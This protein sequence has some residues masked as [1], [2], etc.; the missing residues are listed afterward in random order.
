[1]HLRYQA[2]QIN[3]YLTRPRRALEVQDEFVQ[4]KA[5]QILTVFLRS[6]YPTLQLIFAFSYSI[7][8]VATLLPPHRIQAFLSVLSAS[9]QG[10]ST[11]KRDVAVQC[12]ESLLSRPDYRQEVWK[13]P[14]ILSG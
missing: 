12:L 6:F 8:S 2:Y 11:N 1:M 14:G 3:T 4:L 5:A 7:I 9:I 10:S 13:L